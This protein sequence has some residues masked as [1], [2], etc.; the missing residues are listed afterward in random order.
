VAPGASTSLKVTVSPSNVS[1]KAVTWSLVSAP[2]GVTVSSSGSVKVPSYVTSGTIKVRA[3]A[4]DGRGAY[5]THTLK[6]QKKITALRIDKRSSYSG[7][8]D[9]FVYKSGKLNTINLFSVDLNES[10]GQDNYCALKGLSTGGTVDVTWT[11]SNPSVASVSGNGYITA[12]KA[13]S[14]KITIKALDGSNKSASVTVKV[15]NPVSYME[16]AS[17]A[18]QMTNSTPIIGFGK[19]VTNSVIFGDTY[20][21]PSNTKVTW[22]YKIREYTSNASSYYDRTSTFKAEKLITLSNS[23]KVTVSPKVKDKWLRIG[24]E[25]TLV[26]YAYANDGSGTVATK[27]FLLIRPTTTMKM[28]QW[29]AVTLPT[30]T[31][32]WMHF[33][34]DQWQ[35]FGNAYNAGFIATSSNPD[36]VGVCEVSNHAIHK[37]SHKSSSGSLNYYDIYFVSGTKKGTATITIKTTDGSNKS[38]KFKVTVK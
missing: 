29:N 34:C 21:K 24:G 22:D 28:Y 3:T 15:T 23:G 25:Y 5:D 4:K 32:D 1:S 18:P 7:W 31:Q 2:S 12:H 11:S 19:S 38:C 6:I 13:G 20:G 36:I 9:G 10:S 33:A 27:E 30:Q 16:I 14:A 37:C 17:S 26:L 35:G 8:A